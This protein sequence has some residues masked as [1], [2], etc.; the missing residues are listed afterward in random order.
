MSE[1][2]NQKKIKNMEQ[3]Q[4]RMFISN[5]NTYVGHSLV[6]ILRNDHLNEENPHIIVG[7][8]SKQAPSSI[9]R[10]VKTVVDVHLIYI[11]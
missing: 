3:K 9:P 8:L 1:T 11:Y 5:F 10:G 7:T 6:E 4:L 2:G